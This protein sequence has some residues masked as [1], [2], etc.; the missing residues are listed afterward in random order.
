MLRGQMT[1]GSLT[2]V[3]HLVGQLQAPFVNLSGFL[4]KYI[5][6]NAAAERLRDLRDSFDFSPRELDEVESRLDQ[7]HRL[8]KK[9]GGSVK[10]MLD[11]A[12]GREQTNEVKLE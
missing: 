2:A 8:K 3:V 4:P 7:L 9:Y 11:Y 10:E 1:F 5:A 12:V 6:M